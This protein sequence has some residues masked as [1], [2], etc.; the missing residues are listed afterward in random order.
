M[1][2]AA[3][4][5]FWRKGRSHR[6]LL[7]QLRPVRDIEPELPIR[8][9]LSGVRIAYW[10]IRIFQRP[11]LFGVGYAAR[12]A[13]KSGPRPRTATHCIDE[14]IVRPAGVTVGS[15]LGVKSQADSQYWPSSAQG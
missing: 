7:R 11:L 14:L 8:L 6:T 3:P 1:R 4:S 2:S 13:S 15:R 10:A 5:A 12:S 9:M